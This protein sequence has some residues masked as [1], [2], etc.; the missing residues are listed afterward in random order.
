MVIH[1]VNMLGIIYATPDLISIFYFYFSVNI[2][3]LIILAVFAK[4]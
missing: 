1:L 3:T 4:H 2:N